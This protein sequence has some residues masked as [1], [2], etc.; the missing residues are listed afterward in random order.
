MSYLSST[1]SSDMVVMFEVKTGGEVTV[2][3]RYHDISLNFTQYENRKEIGG[4][5]H[6]KTCMVSS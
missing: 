5:N 2:S 1:N 3:Y 6:Y 4:T